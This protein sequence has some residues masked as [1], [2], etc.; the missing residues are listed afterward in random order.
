[1]YLSGFHGTT[2]THIVTGTYNICNAVSFNRIQRRAEDSDGVTRGS[3][4]N[5]AENNSHTNMAIPLLLTYLP[6]CCAVYFFPCFF[7]VSCLEPKMA[8]F[9]TAANHEPVGSLCFVFIVKC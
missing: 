8:T 4:E 1:M 6:L 9:G 2:L 5:R 7:T 3:H